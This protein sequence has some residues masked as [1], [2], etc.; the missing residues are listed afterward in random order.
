MRKD[1]SRAIELR[2]QGKSYGEISDILKIP[3]ST[4]SYWLRGI[5]LSLSAQAKI[6]KRVNQTSVRA[7]INR[8]KQQTFL[9]KERSEM[10]RKKAEVEVKNLLKNKLFIAGVS[11]YWAEGYKKG[12]QGSRWKSVDFANS[13]PEMILIM[14]R[15]FREICDVKENKFRIQL[16]AHPNINIEEALDFWS[17]QTGI[18]NKQFSKTSTS[19]SSL[20]KS[21]R[22]K[23]TLTKGTVHIR[24]NDVK[25]FF[26]I[27]GWIDGFKKYFL[28]E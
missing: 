21:K 18:S 15:F 16:I 10:I 23:K 14:M 11:L 19:I 4:L 8:N 12:A 26:R 9:A 28:K 3:K 6:N 17:S 2:K 7:L 1:K 5:K 24:I 20:S 13:D 27:I 25:L 22:N